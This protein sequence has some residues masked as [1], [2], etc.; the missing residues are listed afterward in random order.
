MADRQ[1]NERSRPL[2]KV[3][4]DLRDRLARA[5]AAQEYVPELTRAEAGEAARDDA[6]ARAAQVSLVGL[7]LLACIGSAY[8]AQSVLVPVILAWAVATILLPALDLFVRLGIPRFLAVLLLVL[9]LTAVLMALAAFLS[10]PMAFWLGRASELGALLKEKLRSFAEPLSFLRELMAAMNDAT[11]GS[12]GAIKVQEASG[13]LVSNIMAVL[14]PAVS[15]TILFFGALVFYLLYQQSIKTGIVQL[16]PGRDSRLTALRILNDIERNMTV[17][18]GTFTLVNIALGAVTVLLA[19]VV[20]LPNP[21]LWGVLAAVLNYIPYVGVGVMVAVLTVVG[22][23]VFPTIAEA[24]VAPLAYIAITTIEGHFLTPAVIGKRLTL[25]PF[26]VFLAIG[27][28]TWLWGPIG[29]FLAVPLLMAMT[30]CVRHLS[31]D[32]TVDL[33]D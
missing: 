4:Q 8:L 29:A 6:W 32:D 28:W 19:Y 13:S 5:G 20:G 33:P 7:F 16:V 26:A 3:A 31:D 21:L 17:Y 12:E 15:Q 2:K 18:F 30:V 27:F 1:K 14:T 25:N 11:G 22:L 10:V 9:V 23:F 24:M